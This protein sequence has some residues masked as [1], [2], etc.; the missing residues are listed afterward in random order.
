MTSPSNTSDLTALERDLLGHLAFWGNAVTAVDLASSVG[1]SLPG[2]TGAL[3]AMRG[4]GLVRYFE[5]AGGRAGKWQ[6]SAAG[7]RELVR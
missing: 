7:R 2:T 5:G 4:R 1:A 6:A 3:R